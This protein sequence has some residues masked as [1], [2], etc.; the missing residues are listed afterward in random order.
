MLTA[1]LAPAVVGLI[2]SGSAV[3]ASTPPDDSPP[4]SGPPAEATVVVLDE[5]KGDERY[6]LQPAM[7]AG[8]IAHAVDTTTTAG[9]LQL[10]GPESLDATI[11]AVT[12]IEQTAEVTSVAA[13]GSYTI[14]RTVDSYQF[15]VVEGAAD[16]ADGF[17]DDEELE[18]LVGVTLEQS[19]DA[20]GRLVDIV[21]PTG[22]TLTPEQ[23]S[24]VETLI[25][26]G[27]DRP[28]LPDVEVGVGAVWTAQLP[29][30]NSAGGS[31][32]YELASIEQG[33]ATV[34]ITFSGDSSTLEALLSRGFDEITGEFAGQGT[35]VASIENPLA[36]TFDFALQI[37]VVMTGAAGE[38]TM[39][40]D[41][42]SSQVVTV[43]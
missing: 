19:Y 27:G 13:D 10:T 11:E 43:E 39:D 35:L 22:T 38:L 42:T 34:E 23:Q 16:V 37:D 12:T 21:A 33:L 25:E 9:T 6:D 3:S 8:T 29:G 4:D 36:S 7:V 1:L 31:A 24:S 2:A 30:T 40:V 26:E 5:G 17:K 14:L 32:R 18:P 28:P 15:T 41:S 20:D